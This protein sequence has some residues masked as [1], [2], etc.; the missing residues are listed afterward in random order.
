[1]R[2]FDA[3]PVFWAPE[4][5]PSV[6]RLAPTAPGSTIPFYHLDLHGSTDTELRRASD[7][8]HAVLRLGG[9]THRLLLPRLPAKGAAVAVELP[10]DRDFDL[11]TRAA[12]RL[13]TALRR[14]STRLP[15]QAGSIQQR[16]RLVLALR[17]LDG[18]AEGQNYRA[19]ATVLFGPERI[20]DRGWKTHDL[21]SRTIRLV[22]TGESL[23]R[24]GYRN[25]LRN[26]RRSA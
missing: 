7:G 21:R 26:Q 12:H 10:L 4:A 9:A 16:R 2:R 19:I 25:L 17:A 14:G 6:L 8:W 24:T 20:A 18:H 3:Q 13:W 5:L 1:M 15:V 23:I 11:Q 22:Q